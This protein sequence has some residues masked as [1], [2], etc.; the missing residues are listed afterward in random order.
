MVA[1]FFSHY[2]R[3][4]PEIL[5]FYSEILLPFPKSNYY[6]GAIQANGQCQKAFLRLYNNLNQPKGYIVVRPP[7]TRSPDHS[8]FTIFC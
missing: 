2:D 6:V 3:N 5:H 8:L 4:L 1:I 7:A